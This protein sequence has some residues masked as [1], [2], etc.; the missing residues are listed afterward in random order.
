MRDE[1]A[2][3]ATF[4]LADICFCDFESKGRVPIASGTDR[5]ARHAQAIL[6]AWAIGDGPVHLQAVTDLT[7]PLR[8]SDMPREL[9]EFHTRAASGG[10]VFCAHNA[11]FDRM[12]WNHSTRGFPPLLPRMLIDSRAQAA[13]SGLP[14]ALEAAARQVGAAAQKDKR[15]KE[16]IKLFAL[17]S[18]TATPQSHP[19]EWAAF[20]AYAARDVEA[21]RDLFLRTR[22]LP[23]A[24]WLEYWTSEVINDRGVAIDLPL[25]EQAAKMAA[26]DKVISARE[27]AQ[28]TEN[29]VTTV[30]QVARMVAWLG[31]V[32]PSDGRDILVK[33]IEERD[34]E[35]GEVLKPEKS[36]LARD[37]VV[38][39]L[40]YLQAQEPLPAPLLAAQRLLQIRLYGGS[41]TPAK[42]TK[43]LA[44]QVDGVIRGQYN[45][46]GASQT[47]RFSAKGVQIHNLMRDP[48][49][50]EIDAIDALVEGVDPA[51]FA[52]LGDSTPI[53]RKLSLLIR[54]TLVAATGRA[55]AW[56]DWSNIEARITPWLA[57]DKEAEERLEVFRDVDAG[58]EKFDVYTRTAAALSNLPLEE[59]TPPLRQRGKVVELACSFGGGTNALLSMAASYGMHLTESEAK[60]AVERWREQ[61]RW[62]ARFWGRHDDYGSYGLWS[63]ANRA[64]ERPGEFISHGRVGYVFLKHYLGGSLMCRLPSGRFLTYRKIKWEMVDVVDED[65][66][67]VTDRKRE[68]LF[69]RDMGRLKL[70]PGLLVENCTQA[71]A[72][73]LLRATLV[74]LEDARQRWMPVRLHTHDEIVCEAPERQARRAA[75]LLKQAM[76]RGFP[77]TRGL[78]IAAETTVGR[79]YSK[80]KGSMGL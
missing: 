26:A 37:R 74:R 64:L 53:S 1:R 28:L 60:A 78:P 8:W 31:D 50:H 45:F 33:R 32:L 6:L 42:F 27:L 58:V 69:S 65:T 44:A 2:P 5:Y 14:A 62:A 56:G 70:W 3:G 20:C 24:E 21:M 52:T 29:K 75:E 57:L 61:N 9:R 36:S 48:F 80:N 16:L 63:A 59:I 43:M 18:S 11:N 40:A 51:A 19:E 67:L 55:F 17:P 4:A 77:W 35:T 46:N 10:G 7:K 79:W 34:P 54:P 71:A 41:K 38:R 76:E 30:D 12:I 49:E 22:Q 25:A 72:A 13:A 73:D 47:G 23:W 68:L 66:G 15:G 39:L